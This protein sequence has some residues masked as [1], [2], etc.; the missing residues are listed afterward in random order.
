MRIASD[1]EI[2]VSRYLVPEI[3]QF[4]ILLCSIDRVVL[5]YIL[6]AARLA[7]KPSEYT[8]NILYFSQSATTLWLSSVTVI[9]FMKSKSA[10][11]CCCHLVSCKT[12]I[13]IFVSSVAGVGSNIVC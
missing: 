12:E 10:R 3:V 11:Y 5:E 6:A 2:C 7:Y 4:M 9:Y 8:S 1:A 13:T